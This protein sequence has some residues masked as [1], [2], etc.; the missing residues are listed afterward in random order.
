MNDR[1]T[2]LGYKKKRKLK[3]QFS[4]I[5]T[6]FFSVNGFQTSIN[7]SLVVNFLNLKENTKKGGPRKYVKH[8]KNEKSCIFGENESNDFFEKRNC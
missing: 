5:S 8:K 4:K 3:F 6:R 2:V 7:Y 1:N